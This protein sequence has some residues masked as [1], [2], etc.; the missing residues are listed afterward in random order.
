MSPEHCQPEVFGLVDPLQSEPTALIPVPDHRTFLD[1]HVVNAVVIEGGVVVDRRTSH[2][3][4][5][6]Y[7]AS[8]TASVRE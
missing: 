4:S 3:W 8:A 1:E 2:V 7:S 5:K 6:M